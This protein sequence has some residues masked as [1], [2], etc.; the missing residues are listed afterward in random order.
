[1]KTIHD[2]N[3]VRLIDR[4]TARRRELGVTQEQVARHLHV[5]RSWCGKVEQRER[6]LDCLEAWRLCQ[7]YRFEFSEIEAILSAEE[8]RP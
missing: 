4:L 7:I 8:K 5:A 6:R 1:M 3:Y 2:P